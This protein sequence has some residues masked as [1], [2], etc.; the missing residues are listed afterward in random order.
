MAELVSDELWKRIE[1]LLPAWQRIGQD[2]LRCRTNTQLVWQLSPAEAVLRTM[3]RSLPNL[4]RTDRCHPMCKP[5]YA[6]TST[7]LK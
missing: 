4:S 5:N 2:P 6:L 3:W 1:P 7:V